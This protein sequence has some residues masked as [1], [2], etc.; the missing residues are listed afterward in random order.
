MLLKAID[1]PVSC[2]HT[3]N[4]NN[5]ILTH[6]EW[7]FI[8]RTRQ[9]TKPQQRYIRCRLN[10]KLRALGAEFVGA[11]TLLQQTSVTA[12]TALIQYQLSLVER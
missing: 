12:A 3:Q 1:S 4:N 11:A 5:D 6:T 9:F 8:S 10:K 7:D 2:A